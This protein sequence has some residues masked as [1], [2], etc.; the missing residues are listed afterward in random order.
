MYEPEYR[1]VYVDVFA[2]MKRDGT[3]LP[4]SFVWEDGERY[5]IDRV[6]HI[7]PAASLKVGGRGIRYTVKI[8]MNERYIFRDEDRWPFCRHRLAKIFEDTRGH[9][10]TKCAKCGKVVLVDLVNT[11]K[12]RTTITF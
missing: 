5:T 1:K 7:V 6:L 3:V 9:L 8:G 11:R 10:E 12:T 2:V 4:R